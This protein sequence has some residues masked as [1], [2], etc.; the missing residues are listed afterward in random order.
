M[1][2]I[3]IP[4]PSVNSDFHGASAPTSPTRTFNTSPD[5]RGVT[6]S[7]SSPPTIPSRWELKPA[8]PKPQENGKSSNHDDDSF[9]FHFSGQLQRTADELFDGGK[10]K[11]LKP[12]P[13][14]NGL[15]DSLESPSDTKNQIEVLSPRIKKCDSGQLAATIEQSHCTSYSPETELYVF[16][17]HGIQNPMSQENRNE[18]TEKRE[19]GRE[20]TPNSS[21]SSRKQRGTRSLSPFKFSESCTKFSNPLPPSKANDSS[22]KKWKL[23]DLWLKKR[24]EEEVLKKYSVMKKSGGGE[25]VKESSFGS[26]ESSGGGGGGGGRVSRRGA[27]SAHERHYAAKKAAAEEMRRKTV[28]PYKHGLLGCMGFNFNPAVHEISRGIGS[29]TR[30]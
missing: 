2:V 4:S 6:T 9:E 8:L 13:P 20:R 21:A 28:L 25:D 26:T 23:R 24:N 5:G 27:V 30:G 3:M 17:L 22:S 29:L 14:P 10:I 7:A 18:R 12:P 19:R 15:T 16:S 1:E 11:P